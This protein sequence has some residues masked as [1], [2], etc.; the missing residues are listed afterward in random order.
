MPSRH[1]ALAARPLAGKSSGAEERLAQGPQAARSGH[2]LP[3][4][5]EEELPRCGLGWAGCRGSRESGGV[6]GR[7]GQP[8]RSAVNARW[9]RGPPSP[10]QTGV[11]APRRVGGRVRGAGSGLC[12]NLQGGERGRSQAGRPAGSGH[13]DHTDH[14]PHHYP[15]APQNCLSK[16]SSPSGPDPGP[17][18]QRQEKKACCRGQL[19]EAPLGLRPPGASRMQ[20]TPPQKPLQAAASA[21][22]PQS[23]QPH[24]S[25]G[26]CCG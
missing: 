7:D 3:S 23:D 14:S 10:R 25:S 19:P 12:G 4:S 22:R 9:S 1:K 15:R 8:A 20:P 17:K 16:S 26:P 5:W 13:T 6:L 21:L 18:G 24:P 2:L 11:R